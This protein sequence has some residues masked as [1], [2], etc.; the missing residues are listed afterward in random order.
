M[1]SKFRNFAASIE[2][3]VYTFII[4]KGFSPVKKECPSHGPGQEI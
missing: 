4:Y 3:I 2:K 1:S